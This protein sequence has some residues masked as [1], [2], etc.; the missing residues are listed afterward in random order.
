MGGNGENWSF[1]LQE[2]FSSGIST[3]TISTFEK[4][5]LA[6]ESVFKPK[7]VE[8]WQIG[9]RRQKVEEE[10]EEQKLLQDEFAQQRISTN[11]RETRALLEMSGREFRGDVFRKEKKS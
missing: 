9:E 2:D 11:K 5:W 4:C 3:P 6:G 7:N 8:I 1:F 10:E